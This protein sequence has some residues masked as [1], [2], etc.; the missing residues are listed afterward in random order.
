MLAS[1]HM[2]SEF[3]LAYYIRKSN[4]NLGDLLFYFAIHNPLCMNK[5]QALLMLYK[6]GKE[7]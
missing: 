1:S 5:C 7:I 3:F 2:N 4:Y 6:E